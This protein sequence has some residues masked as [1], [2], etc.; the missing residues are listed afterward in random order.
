VGVA[1]WLGQGLW[2]NE[3]NLVHGAPLCRG[4]GLSHDLR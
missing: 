4:R 1:R 2:I 3:A